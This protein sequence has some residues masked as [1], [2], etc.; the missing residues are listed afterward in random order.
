MV[1][2]E[3]ANDFVY[4]QLERLLSDDKFFREVVGRVNRE[5]RILKENALKEKESQSKE[6]KKINNR[7]QRNHE[8]YEDREISRDEFLMRREELNHQLSALWQSQS[9]TSLIIMEEEKKEI[10]K[11]AIRN[12]LQNFSKVL[13]SNIDRTIRKRLLHLLISEITIDKNRNIDSIKLKLS[14]E[15]IR[16]LQN[17]GGTP[18]DGAPSVFMFR[19]LGIKTM[20]LELVLS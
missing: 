5:H 3:K 2:V 8:L 12:I 7:Q 1:R 16:F 10:P 17:N 6:M 14:D 18:P 19:E 20:D 15:L 9:E 4:H 11:E 13:S